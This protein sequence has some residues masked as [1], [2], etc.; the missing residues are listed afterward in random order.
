MP[1]HRETITIEESSVWRQPFTK[2]NT[3]KRIFRH[4]LQIKTAVRNKYSSRNIN[5]QAWN[6]LYLDETCN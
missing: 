3:N 4:H 2:P 5:A 6:M 1:W